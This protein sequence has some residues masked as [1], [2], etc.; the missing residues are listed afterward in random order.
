MSTGDDCTCVSFCCMD[1]ELSPGGTNAA[2][3]IQQQSGTKCQSLL[4]VQHSSSSCVVEATSSV[5]P[6]DGKL[7]LVQTNSYCSSGVVALGIGPF[8]DGSF[9]PLHITFSF[10][11]HPLP[12]LLLFPCFRLANRRSIGGLVS[13]LL[14]G[15]RGKESNILGAVA[16][17]VELGMSD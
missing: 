3:I 8:N 16:T 2:Y 5:V 1:P 9:A 15:F 17:L 12:L 6:S 4:R 7:S 14:G 13:C 11:R 10:R